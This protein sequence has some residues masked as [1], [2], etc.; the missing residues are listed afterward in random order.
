MSGV[1][2]ESVLWRLALGDG[3]SY[4]GRVIRGFAVGVVAGAVAASVAW[5]RR[6][7]VQLV[8]ARA[9]AQGG[10]AELA[11]LNDAL[12]ERR[13]H[14]HHCD[15]EAS[16]LADAVRQL[17]GRSVAVGEI[18]ER[19]GV[20]VDGGNRGA[21]VSHLVEGGEEFRDDFAAADSNI[22]RVVQRMMGEVDSVDCPDCGTGLDDAHVPGCA[23]ARCGSCGRQ[24][25]SCEHEA[26]MT[27][28]TGSYPGTREVSEGLAADLNDLHVKRASGELRWDE[29]TQRLVPR[30]LPGVRLGARDGA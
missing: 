24:E 22:A 14:A 2:S 9:Q 11:R 29:T 5:R 10:V 23:I 25:L 21:D 12:S 15:A 13:E 4:A 30:R 27:T 6:S 3:G 8:E 18:R 7:D 28:W 17:A 16:L 19:A 1:E 26:P 20:Q